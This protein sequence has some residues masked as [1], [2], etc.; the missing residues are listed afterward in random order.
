MRDTKA[1]I[2]KFWFEET[3]PAQWFQKNPDFDEDIRARFEPDY[4]LASQD[5]YDGWMESA[6]GCLALIILLDQFPRN[7]YRETPKMFAMDHKALNVAKHA[8]EKKFDTMMSLHEKVFLYLPYEHSE[9]LVDQ[10]KS[11]ELFKPTE[12]EDPIFYH[13]A[14][15]HYDVIKQFG[16]FPHRNDILERQNTKSAE[17]YLV[18]PESGF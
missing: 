6:K 2:L 13:Y 8:V 1:E 3:K 7:M 16:R 18:Q 9:E 15:R 5:I 17:E 12:A 10:E 4:I 14:V 11:L